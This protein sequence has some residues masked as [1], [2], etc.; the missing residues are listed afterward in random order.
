MRTETQAGMV[1]EQRTIRVAA[2][3]D[4]VYRAFMGIGGRRGWYFANWLW[5]LRG[6]LDRVIGG[7]GLRRG[8]RHPD[9]L[10]VGD[11]LDFWRVETLGPG[12]LLRLRAEMKTPGRAWLQFEAREAEDG[13]VTD[14]EQTASFIPRGLMGL[15]YWYALYPVHAWIFRGMVRAIARRAEKAAVAEAKKGSIGHGALR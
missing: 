12:R 3:P 5:S 4:A 14:L 1:L 2:T 10:R 13:A 7:A 8:R 9:E 6:M 11:A 15:V